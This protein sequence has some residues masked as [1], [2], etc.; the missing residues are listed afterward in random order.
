[1]SCSPT[2]TWLPAVALLSITPA[3]AGAQPAADEAAAEKATAQPAAAESAS[4]SAA[5][6]GAEEAKEAAPSQAPAANTAPRQPSPAAT[7]TD[8]G[9]PPSQPEPGASLW[10]A[11]SDDE[12]LA[13]AAPE[14][15]AAAPQPSDPEDVWVGGPLGTYQNH[16]MGWMGVRGGFI[17]DAGFDAFSDEDGLVQFSLG[18]GRTLLSADALSVAAIAMWDYGAASDKARGADTDLDVH[19]F[20]IGPEIRYHLVPWLYVFGRPLPAAIHTRASLDAP[21]MDATLYSRDWSFG[22]DATAGAAVQ[23]WGKRSAASTK[24][25]VWAQFEGGYGWATSVDLKFRADDADAAPQR[26]ED[27]D[28]GT[29][30]IRGPM[31]RISIALTF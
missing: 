27:V 31:F 15:N 21:V 6:A 20:A 9:A 1:M 2:L 16:F 3:L 26:V 4:P 23:L 10:V 7:G 11:P 17:S 28:L 12:P 25:R 13:P 19:R 22:F 5:D 18:F 29:L 14:P 30:A 8:A 24:P